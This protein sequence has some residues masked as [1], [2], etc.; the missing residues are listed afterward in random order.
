MPNI[1][2]LL[3]NPF[4]LRAFIAI[5]LISVLAATA[6]SFTTFRG[7]S[8]LVASIAH[9]ALAGAALA[10]VLDQYGIVKELD[11]TLSALLFGIIMA[12]IIGISEKIEHTEK[13]EIAIGISFALSM[14][15]AVLFISMMREYS[16]EA[17]AL[18]L[19]DILLLSFRDILVL[20]IITAI[21]AFIFI[22]FMREFIFLSFDPEGTRAMGVNVDFYH[23]LML[24]LVASSTVVL[25]RGIGAI[26]VYAVLIIPSAIANKISKDV[27]Q[28]LFY[29]F[30]ISLTCGI[31]GI[32]VSLF[33][34]V[35]PS[36][37]IGLLLV[38]IYLITALR[39]RK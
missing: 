28:I 9:S 11:P 35:A 6:G 31:I 32:I 37:I 39:S 26:L 1:F 7:L 29:S 30:V 24:V 38:L 18:I 15:L 17:W 19:G 10:V 12:I 33:I 16:V 34:S 22:L 3:T 5:L 8:F 27:Y 20:T 14:S 23:I 4:V 36:S 2:L 25:L 21:V 13:I